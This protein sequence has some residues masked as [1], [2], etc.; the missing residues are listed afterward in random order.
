[1]EKGLRQN[2]R[3]GYTASKIPLVRKQDCFQSLYGK[4]KGNGF[5]LIL[6]FSKEKKIHTITTMHAGCHGD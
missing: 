5:L 6:I 4:R 2:D 3:Y 1:M